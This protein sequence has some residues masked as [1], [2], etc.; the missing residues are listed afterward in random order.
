MASTCKH[1]A[2]MLYYSSAV[3]NAA[4][5][6][7]NDFTRFLQTFYIS[8]TALCCSRFISSHSLLLALAI[9]SH[10]YTAHNNSTHQFIIGYYG[11]AWFCTESPKPISIKH[12]LHIIAW[13]FIQYHAIITQLVPI[14]SSCLVPQTTIL[15]LSTILQSIQK[16]P[17]CLN[18]HLKT[19]SLIHP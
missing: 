11:N 14:A 18:H 17:S 1:T 12:H 8:V 9:T 19:E 2:D 3:R 15:Y 7:F 13:S 4:A 16:K 5:H 10:V 6:A